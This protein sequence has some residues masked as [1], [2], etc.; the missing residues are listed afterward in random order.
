MVLSAW[1][2]ATEEKLFVQS[3]PVGLMRLDICI[4]ANSSH[5]SDFSVIKICRGLA[6]FNNGDGRV[7]KHLFLKSVSLFKTDNHFDRILLGY[8]FS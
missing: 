7:C 6:G 1:S 8:Q 3:S 4:P 5:P 2:V